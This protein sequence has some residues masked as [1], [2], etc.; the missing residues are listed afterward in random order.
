MSGSCLLNTSSAIY[1]DNKKH[2][3]KFP[4]RSYGVYYCALHPIESHSTDNY[5]WPLVKS[6]QVTVAGFAS[7]QSKINLE[8]GSLGLVCSSLLPFLL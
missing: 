6:P 2:I 8:A 7:L 5:L 4:K 3:P 1:C